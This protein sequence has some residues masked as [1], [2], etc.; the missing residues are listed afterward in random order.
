MSDKREKTISRKVLKNIRV[1][2]RE[3]KEWENEIIECKKCT[4]VHKEDMETEISS[5]FSSVVDINTFEVTM[6]EEMKDILAYLYWE[7][8]VDRDFL[9]GCFPLPFE[10]IEKI[11]KLQK[12]IYPSNLSK[13]F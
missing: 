12:E 7:K 2:L 8:I 6:Y 1:C 5:Y 13:L 4:E 10:E 11:A 9:K 3:I